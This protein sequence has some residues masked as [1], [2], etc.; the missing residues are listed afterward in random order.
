MNKKHWIHIR[1]RLVVR[2]FRPENLTVASMVRFRRPA[3]Y[4]HW[5]RFYWH[6][7]DNMRR[8][9]DV[10]GFPC[11]VI[12]VDFSERVSESSL[13]E[14]LRPHVEALKNQ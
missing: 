9:V 12:F 4:Q 2:T 3:D 5:K 7:E 1:P 14:K 8:I 13:E 10:P 6:Y 11:P